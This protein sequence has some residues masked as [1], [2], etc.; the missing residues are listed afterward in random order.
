[1]ARYKDN[2]IPCPNDT[3]RMKISGDFKNNNIIYFKKKLQTT[4]EYLTES[5]IAKNSSYV[6]SQGNFGAH[7]NGSR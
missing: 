1:M 7:D 6:S 3:F 4:E 2:D 5:R